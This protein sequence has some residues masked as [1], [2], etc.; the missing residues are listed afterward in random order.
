M[1]T[2]PNIDLNN[3]FTNFC[4]LITSFSVTLILFISALSH[5][6][7]A[8]QAEPADEAL[9]VVP[10]AP[11]WVSHSRFS[12]KIVRPYQDLNTQKIAYVF[13]EV[14]VGE[15]NRAIEFEKIPTTENDWVSPEGV[16]AFCNV[17]AEIFS[18]NIDMMSVT[19]STFSLDKSLNHLNTLKLQPKD[20]KSFSEVVKSFF[21][22]EPAGILSY[23]L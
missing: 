15:P 16:K 20:L 18:C 5:L 11:E 7:F 8:N 3:I 13:P 21:G 10:T 9:Y 1:K 22:N 12:I 17:T 14:L 4:N 6:S 2:I 23:D 19:K